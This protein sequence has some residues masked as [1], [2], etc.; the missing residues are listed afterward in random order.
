MLF[1]CLLGGCD[2]FSHSSSSESGWE[3][4]QTEYSL[5]QPLLVGDTLYAA[6]GDGRLFARAASNG[7]ILWS[8][9]IA[10]RAIEGENI[11]AA[12]GIIAV[13]VQRETIGVNAHSGEIVWKYE[14]PLDTVD[15]GPALPGAV[16]GVH[17]DT[18]GDIVFIPSWGGSITAIDARSGSVRWRWA[19]PALSHR[20]GAEG[21]TVAGGVVYATLWHFLSTDG[22]TSE[23][24]VVALDAETG[25]EEWQTVLPYAGSVVCL[26]GRPAIAGSLIAVLTRTG[27][28][29]GL[30][31]S[32]GAVR[33]QTPREG[34]ASGELRATVL[35]SPTAAGDTILVDAGTFNLRAISAVDGRVLWKAPYLGQFNHD[36]TLT[37]HRI[38]AAD[39]TVLHEFDRH[40]GALLR[41]HQ[42]PHTNN[43]L[44]AASVAVD[45]KFVYAVVNGAVWAFRY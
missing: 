17:I 5:A 29:F 19:P 35:T 27:E 15:G 37:T 22:I 3:S 7:R 40:S 4:A 1:I 28:V 21:V 31:A 24:R 20:F 9:Q 38:F 11:V 12:A 2:W 6:S 44:F 30:D 16:R 18:N 36:L 8:A 25:S 45:S 13:P 34:L 41:N 42:Q 32:S 23:A 43:G 39:A 10:S 33:W 14:A 26:P